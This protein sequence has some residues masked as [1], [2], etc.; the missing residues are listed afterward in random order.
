MQEGGLLW[1]VR[2]QAERGGYVSTQWEW[3]SVWSQSLSRTES[4]KGVVSEP[5]LCE[6][7]SMC[8]WEMKYMNEERMNK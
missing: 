8:G 3:A 6:V 1:R 5:Q 4:K 2:S 7:G